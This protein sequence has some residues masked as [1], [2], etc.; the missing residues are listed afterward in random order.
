MPSRK[1]SD[2]APEMAEKAEALVRECDLAGIALLITCTYRSNDEQAKAYAQ[3]RTTPGAIVTHAKPGQSR[4]NL[5]NEQGQPA[6]R[7]I[8][9][10]P[11]RN[12]K[13]VW[14]T[15]DPAWQNV[16]DIGESLGLEWAGRWKRN[17]EWAHFQLKE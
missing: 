2:L 13:A 7:A 17:R 3:G 12:G 16:A 4:H 10:V 11:I 6:S 9:V 8:D 14:D 15:S 1:L 5:V